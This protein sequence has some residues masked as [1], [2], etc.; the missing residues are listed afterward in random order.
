MPLKNRITRRLD[1]PAPVMH[2]AVTSGGGSGGGVSDPA[3]PLPPNGPDGPTDVAFTT[4]ITYSTAS[5]LAY[6]AAT[7]IAPSGSAPE[8][9]VLQVSEGS[10]FLAANTL[11]FSTNVP[12]ATATGLKPATAYYGRVAGVVRGVQGDWASGTPYP[13]TTASDTAPAGI[14][15]SISAAWVGAGDLLVTCVPPTEANFKDIQIVVRAASGGTIYRTTYSAAG[16]LLYTWSMNYNDTGGALDNS[17]YVELRSRTFSNVL[18]TVVNTGLVTKSPPGTPTGLSQSWSADT[19]GNGLA[20]AN[21]TLAWLLASD[22]AHYRA[23]IDTVA[24]E[25]YGDS[26]TYD[27]GLNTK[28]HGSPDPALAYSLFAID[29]FGTASTAASGTARNYEPPAA[30]VSLSSGAVGSF[31]VAVVGGTQAADFAAYEYVFKRDGV[32]V[33]TLES[34]SN[35]QQYELTSNEDSGLHSWTC[36]VRQKDLFN[37]FSTATAS[38][39]VVVEALTQGLLRALAAYTDSDSNSAATLAALKDG[40]TTSGGVTYSA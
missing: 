17:L 10:G 27:I 7:W 1:M 19:A 30:T 22:A 13:I 37:Q 15:T 34:K 32:T 29:A 31:L 40:N 9:Y 11:S 20:S 5:P 3:P 14:P 26:Y 24:R 21:W 36:T 8:R 33:R 25:V 39:V 6:I 18:G 35:E 28:E 12:Y 4:G 16:R 23:T 38:S 2:G